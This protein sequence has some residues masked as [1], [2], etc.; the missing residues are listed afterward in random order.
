MTAPLAGKGSSLQV[1]ISSVYTTVS[2]IVSGQPPKRGQEVYTWTELA[3]GAVRRRGTGQEDGGE[4]TIKV[5]YDPESVSQQ[6]L[7]LK[8][9]SPDPE[10][11]K[12]IDSQLN[13]TP[14]TAVISNFEP[15]EVTAG[16]PVTATL[17]LAV[18]DAITFPTP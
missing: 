3:S 6:Y 8:A 17:T 13:E 5:N 9:K 2:N 16:A 18:D 14:F 7:M 10:Q 12:W 1:S 11:F 15:D 4:R